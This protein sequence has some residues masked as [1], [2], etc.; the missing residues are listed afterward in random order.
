MSFRGRQFAAVAVSLAFLAS[1]PAAADDDDDGGDYGKRPDFVTGPISRIVYDGV[2]DDLLTGGLGKDGLAFLTPP[3]ALADP[4]NPTAAELRRLAIYNNYRALIDTTEG[5]GYGTIYGPNIRA[6]GSDSMEQGLI[7]GVEVIAFANARSDGDDEDDDDDGG[8]ARRNVTMMVQVPDSFD[9][10]QACIV[11]G[12]SSG[13][14][15]VYGAIGTSGEWGL[16][17]GC[18]VTYTDK[19]TGTGAHYLQDNTVGLI[20]GKRQDARLAGRNSTFTAPISKRQRQAFNAETPNRF[21]FKHAHSQR[22]PEKDWGRDVLR[23]IE[24][25][26]YVLNKEYP[27]AGLHP[28]NTIV[29]AS[30][31]SNG[32]GSSV[33]AAE[34]DRKGLIDGIAV[35]EPNVNPRFDPRFTIVQGDDAPIVK[36][37]RSLYDYTSL[38]HLYQG[39]ANLDPAIADAGANFFGT[40]GDFEALGVARCASLAL[41]GLLSASDLEDQAAEA[42]RI[43][44]DF[45][46]QPEQNIVQPSHWTFFIPQAVTITYAKAYSR[47]SVLDNVCGYSFAADVALAPAP[48]SPSGEAILFSTSG[49]IPPTGGVQVINNDSLGGPL[50]DSFSISSNGVADQNIEGALC[51]RALATGRDP[52]SGDRLEGAE[53]KRHKA[54]LRGIKEVRAKGDLGGLPAIFVTGRNDA[55]L[56]INHTSRAYF[57]LNAV[58]EGTDSNLRYYEILNAQHLDAFNAFF[59]EFAQAFIPLHHYFLEALD[60]ML[61]H[62]RNGTA[63][64]PSQVVRTVPRSIEGPDLSDA[65]LPE[66]KSP[67]AEGDEITF[68]EGQVRIP[69]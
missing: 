12:P 67:A 25:A 53:R 7:P 55:I 2:N 3:P 33:R 21:A 17:N 42:Q 34:Q 26:F 49:G 38:V 16:K 54:L 23:S 24:F 15:G 20:D 43:I 51:A 45:A 11:T 62:L 52:V 37:S 22:N 65:N 13:S 47:A 41:L 64:P 10:A 30:S 9:P 36:H 28:S 44:N 61:D 57:G 35:S 5:G 31:I 59:P 1:V 40:G 29:I 48:I 8:S 14:R 68:A 69:D 39:C 18:A 56:P 6:D 4:L 46:I 60:I 66:I 50:R 32:G 63:L 27:R 19:G 58:V